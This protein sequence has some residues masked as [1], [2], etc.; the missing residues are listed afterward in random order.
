MIT[1]RKKFIAVFFPLD[2]CRIRM[3]YFFCFFSQRLRILKTEYGEYCR[4]LW[5]APVIQLFWRPNFGTVW[6]RHQ[7]GVTVLQ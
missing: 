2:K 5:R 1:R 4:V 6:V 3:L 7:L